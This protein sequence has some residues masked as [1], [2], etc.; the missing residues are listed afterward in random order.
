MTEITHSSGGMLSYLS[1]HGEPTPE[2]W[3]SRYDMAEKMAKLGKTSGFELELWVRGYKL[4]NDPVRLGVMERDGDNG[5]RRRRKA[6]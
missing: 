6:N 2:V 1:N 5:K 4:T 3:R